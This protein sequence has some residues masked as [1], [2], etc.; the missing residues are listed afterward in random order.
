MVIDM[1]MWA[2]PNFE[3]TGVIRKG[4]KYFLYMQSAEILIATRRGGSNFYKRALINLL[5]F[6]STPPKH[7]NTKQYVSPPIPPLILIL[8]L[9]L[10]LL[11]LHLLPPP[12]TMHSLLGKMLWCNL[13]TDGQPLPA[14]SKN[15]IDLDTAVVSTSLHR[16]QDWYFQ[17]IKCAC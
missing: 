10:P 11:L 7:T 5:L 1:I 2:L 9:S 17:N 3:H 15:E 12:P 4:L 8:P 13:G 6:Q 14:L 16:C